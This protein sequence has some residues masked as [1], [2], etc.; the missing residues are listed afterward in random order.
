MPV[1]ELPFRA[2]AEVCLAWR[3]RSLPGL[4]SNLVCL[5][6]FGRVGRHSE[7]GAIVCQNG[8]AIWMELLAMTSAFHDFNVPTA[9]KRAGAICL[10]SPNDDVLHDVLSVSRNQDLVQDQCAQPHGKAGHSGDRTLRARQQPH[11]A[12]QCH[13][14]FRTVDRRRVTEKR[15]AGETACVRQ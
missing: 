11:L 7:F 14:N 4:D 8:L 5:P 1:L 2:K 3:K 15:R 10:S 13:F 6:G 9:E 12:D